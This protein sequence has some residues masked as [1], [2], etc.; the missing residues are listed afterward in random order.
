MNNQASSQELWTAIGS[1]AGLIAVV[2]TLLI[3]FIN[4]RERRQNEQNEAI[5][6]QIAETTSD[7]DKEKL[8]ERLAKLAGGV[9]VL[10]VGAATEVELKETKFRV[11]DA[12]SATRAAIEE[13]IVAGGGTAYIRAL[14]VLEKL[15]KDSNF[16]GLF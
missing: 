11:E 16:Y 10:Y 7:Y 14:S 1:L 5:K 6:A 9:A 2:V 4:R 3:Y 13:G 8:Q 12:I 15:I